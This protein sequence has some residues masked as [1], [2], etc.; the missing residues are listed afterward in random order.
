MLSGHVFVV[1]EWLAVDGK[2]QELWEKLSD[3]IALTKEER[4]C[5]RAHVTRQ[6]SH[7]GSPGVSIYKIFLLQE[8]QSITDFNL[9]CET[10]YVTDFFKNY[11]DNPDSDLVSQWTCRLFNEENS[12]EFPETS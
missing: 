9:H 10:S 2:D 12:P 6:V 8:Y 5:I 4:G 3:L 1:S 7:P 11:I